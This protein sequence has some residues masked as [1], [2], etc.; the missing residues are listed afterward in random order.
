[1][2]MAAL[3]VA[4]TL[5]FSGL[6]LARDHDDHKYKEDH[7]DRRHDSNYNWRRGEDHDENDHHW[8]ERSREREHRNDGYYGGQVYNRV[9]RTYP[10]GGYGYPSGG[11]GYPSGG[12]G[13][14]SGGYGYPSGGYGYP[15]GGYGYPG[16]VYGRGGYGNGSASGAGYNQGLQDGS[17]QA[18]KDV[19]QG[20][21]FN[22]YPRGSSHSDHGYHSYMGD[23]HV[24]Q[25]SYDQGY[26]TGYQSNYGG[27][28]RRGWG[29]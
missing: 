11:Y 8:W 14:P 17:Y 1:M 10:N 16:S 21:P 25:A 5:M 13:Y 3:A 28:G 12:Y 24:Y 2:R 7:A 29:F 9:P 20:K 18:R 15:S 23:K 26:Q 6:A 27:R 22:P 4:I 19:A